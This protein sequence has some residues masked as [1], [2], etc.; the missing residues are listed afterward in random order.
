MQVKVSILDRDPRILPEMG[1]KVEFTREPGDALN[2]AARRVM[3]PGAAVTQGKDGARVWVVENGKA[4][5][6]TVDVGPAR[7]N[8]VEIRRGLAG[9]EQV[10]LDAPAALKEG[11]R[12]RIKSSG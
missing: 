6:R 5:A 2:N 4:S 9:G 3:I 12:V 1:A 10:V 7:G 11:A 8:Q